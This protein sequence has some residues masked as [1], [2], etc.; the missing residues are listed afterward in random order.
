MIDFD[1][2]L[3]PEEP[4]PLP[5]SLSVAGSTSVVVGTTVEEVRVPMIVLPS[6]SVVNVVMIS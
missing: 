3:N 5:P 2:E 1:E 6:D 4:P